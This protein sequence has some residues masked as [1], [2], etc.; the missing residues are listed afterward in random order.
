MAFIKITEIDW[1]IRLLVITLT[2][3]KN[4]HIYVVPVTLN[5]N[6]Y[7]AAFKEL[8]LLQAKNNKNKY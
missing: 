2:N 5:N 7:I 8:A 4:R 3:S 6:T 1:K